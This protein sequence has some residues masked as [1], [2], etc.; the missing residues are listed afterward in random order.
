MSIDVRKLKNGIPVLMENVDSVD[1]VSLGIYVKTGARDEFPEE[2]GVSHYIEH[3][4][5]KGTETRSAKDISEEMD[6]EGGIMNAFTSRGSTGYYVRML[7]SRIE[8]GIEL[9]SDM[10]LN[11]TFT[12]ENLERE[13]NVIIEEIRMYDDIPEEVI[14]DE[15]IRFALTGVQSNSIAGTVESVKGI[16]R[17]IFLNY[18][19]EQYKASNMVIAVAGKIDQDYIMELLEKGFGAIKDKKTNRKIDNSYKINSGENRIK[20]DTNQVHLCFN[21]KGIG[22]V[23]E[24]RYAASIISSALGGNMSSRLFQ[25]IRE[26]KGLAYSVYAYSTSFLE[27][28]VFTVYAGTTKDSYQEVIEIIK[29]EFEDIRENGITASELEKC[30]NQLL[31]MLTFALEGTKGKMDAMANSYLIFNRIVEVDELID[32]IEKI[33][34]DDIKKVAKIMFDEK[35]YSSTVLGDIE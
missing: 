12:E 28:G 32:I 21:T 5:F 35:Y 4:M 24:N 18:Y 20:R 30:K 11:S 33:T 15:N 27:D 22:S 9:L 31:S 2:S 19:N 34:L 8:K 17:E 10:F 25:K 1:T 26:E 7:S 23:D 13:R 16:N 6:N 14:H 3:M 29:N